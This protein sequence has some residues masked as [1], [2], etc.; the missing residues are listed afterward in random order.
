MNI[1]I[2]HVRS[3]YFMII[4]AGT[5]FTKTTML[6][7]ILA[8][9]TKNKNKTLYITNC[10]TDDNI[11][12]ETKK[13]NKLFF[14]AS[15]NHEAMI[16]KSVLTIRHQEYYGMAADVNFIFEYLKIGNISKA[17][18]ICSIIYDRGGTSDRYPFIRKSI[19]HIK[20]SKTL[21]LCGWL[22][23]SGWYLIRAIK[24]LYRHFCK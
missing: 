4:N 13:I 19:D 10:K 7:D 22:I 18:D 6:L 9:I 21:L 8:H 20:I 15:L 11:F 1:G 12:Y 16:Y 23:P 17:D 5:V 24:D 14:P 3:N 2:N